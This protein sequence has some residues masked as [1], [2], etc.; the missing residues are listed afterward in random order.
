MI[1][2]RRRAAEPIRFRCR[3]VTADGPTVAR[4]RE[5][6]ALWLRRCTDLGEAR[7]C[8]VI[9]AVNEAL[10]NAAEFAYLHDPGPGTIDVN[11]VL[12]GG[13]LIVDVA[14]RGR[15]RSTNPA[16]PQRCRGRGIPL[17]YALADSV[18]IDTTSAGTRVRLRFDGAH[19]VRS[20]G[21]M[22]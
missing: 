4:V 17:M 18:A 15:W 19:A 20:T 10:A 12:D 6:F 5:E 21:A 11:A 9:L 13:V 16:S 7:L 2:I 1:T 8:D 3:K 22:A 14:D